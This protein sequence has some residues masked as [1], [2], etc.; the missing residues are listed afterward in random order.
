MRLPRS[1]Y[2]RET[3]CVARELLGKVLVHGDRELIIS[4]TE[5]YL[6]PEDLASHARF[7]PTPR[8]KIMWGN[9][10]LLYVYLIY[11]MHEMMNIITGVAGE[12]GA[13]LIR[14]GLTADTREHVTGPG[15]VSQYL[16]ITRRENGVD[17]VTSPT[18]WINDNGILP[19]T[20]SATPRIGIDYAGSWAQEPLRFVGH[21]A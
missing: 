20:T 6:G 21:F 3:A 13:V 19:D 8:K 1:F 10:G 12:P 5:A 7:G 16:G 17:I 18:L 2:Q 11:G 14:A 4:E 9:G 15:K